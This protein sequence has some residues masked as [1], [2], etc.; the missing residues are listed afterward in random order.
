M[1][2]SVETAQSTLCQLIEAVAR[3]ER[4]IIAHAG[5]PVVELVALVRTDAPARNQPMP[6]TEE[7]LRLWGAW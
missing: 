4:V 1:H 3:G 5:E 7:D 6:L 2:V